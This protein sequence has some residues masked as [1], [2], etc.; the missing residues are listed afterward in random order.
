MKET[1]IK[2]DGYTVT[3]PDENDPDTPMIATVYEDKLEQFE[4]DILMS[5]THGLDAGLGGRLFARSDTPVEGLYSARYPSEDMTAQTLTPEEIDELADGLQKS[6]TK[7]LQ[8]NNI[9]RRYII[10]NDIIG[11]TYESIESNVNTQYTLSFPD[12][13]GRNKTKKLETAKALIR[14]F[15]EQINIKQIIRE[16]IPLTY[17]EGTYITCLRYDET[18]GYRPLPARCRVYQ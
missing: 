12:L 3:I 14:D 18:K 13:T 10:T 11:K 4:N 1:T 15:N 8:L 9:V 16:C 17:C 5:A 6:L 7:T 2:G